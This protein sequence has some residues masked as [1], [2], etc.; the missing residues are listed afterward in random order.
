[1]ATVQDLASYLIPRA[2]EHKSVVSLPRLIKL[3]YL[4][5]WREALAH[6]VQITNLNWKIGACG[7]SADEI[8]QQLV[9]DVSHFTLSTI[10]DRFGNPKT[11]VGRASQAV[12]SGLTLSQ[13]S[14][15]DFILNVAKNRE[16]ESLVALVSSTY[17]VATN[18]PGAELN[19]PKLATEYQTEILP[20]LMAQ[21]LNK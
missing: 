3:M 13:Q 5:D 18:E 9:T 15:V 12:N 20:K 17:P 8:Y 14:S 10:M 6:N 2:M 1:M 11:V 21:K 7:P 19:L 4:A 16:W